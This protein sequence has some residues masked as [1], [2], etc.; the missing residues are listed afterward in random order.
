MNL[1]YVEGS[2]PG[3]VWAH[4]QSGVVVRAVRDRSCHFPGLK[5]SAPAT[6]GLY[7]RFDELDIPANHVF[8]AGCGTGEGLRHLSAV[9]RRV[10]GIDR[11]V[12]VL[13]CAKQLA[14]HAR[15]IHSDI[16]T[17]NL[18]RDAA[19]LAY[20]IDVLGHIESPT[21][22][23]LNISRNLE[24]ARGLCVAEP[25]ASIGQQLEPPQC[26]AF[27]GRTLYSV[28]IKGGF[29]IEEW[30]N[31]HHD[32]V[33]G[34]AV[35]SNGEAASMLYSAESELER[36]RLHVAETLARRACSVDSAALRLEALLTLARVQVQ[37][38]RRDAATATLLE[39]Q[40]ID[41]SDA[42]PQAGLALLARASGADSQ[43]YALA[44]EALALDP[45]DLAAITSL[46]TLLHETEPKQALQHWI[47][48][49]ALAPEHEGIVA[50]LCDAAVRVGELEVAI[51]ALNQSRRFGS[52]AGGVHGSLSLAWLLLQVGRPEQAATIARQ[53]ARSYPD[54]EGLSELV[55]Y[56]KGCR[57][58]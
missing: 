29:R 12:A 43:A 8:D 19:Q 40:R 11:N 48:A 34:Y 21:P 3:E 47:A 52:V 30:L 28:L 18:R 1:H 39:A 55:D 37:R 46:A 17:C 44:R 25:R 7:R 26:R 5:G 27:T 42:R 41:P 13:N 50:R 32:F 16:A 36:G 38:S 33:A 2:L 15:L 24:G 10:T 49:H 20:V 35:S 4:F 31:V 22:A 53:T 9:Y 58:T 51:A 54:A 45:A 6:L 57:V 14:P 56:L 23:L